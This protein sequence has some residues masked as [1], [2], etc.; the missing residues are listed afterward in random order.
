MVGKIA[1]HVKVCISESLNFFTYIGANSALKSIFWHYYLYL[2][3][4]L[5]IPIS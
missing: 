1:E 2:L 4:K 3:L 5:N